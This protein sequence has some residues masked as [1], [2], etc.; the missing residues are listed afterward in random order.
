VKWHEVHFGEPEVEQRGDQWRF[1]VP[2]YLGEISPDWV[3]VELYADADL[4]REAVRQPMTRGD[5]VSG[6]INGYIYR[7]S[8]PASRPESHFTPRVTTYHP[9][10]CTPIESALVLWQK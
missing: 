10:A 2:V 9:E 8:V 5:P 7:A 6:A 3:K 1:G 4:E